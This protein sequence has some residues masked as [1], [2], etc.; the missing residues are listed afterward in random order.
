MMARYSGEPDQVK[1]LHWFA[2]DDKLH[3]LATEPYCVAAELTV[4]SDCPSRKGPES[5][6]AL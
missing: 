1:S 6:Q 5:Y 4:R 3:P 2:S